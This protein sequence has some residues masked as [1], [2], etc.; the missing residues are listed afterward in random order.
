MNSMDTKNDLLTRDY[1]I[2]NIEEDP[3][4]KNSTKEFFVVLALCM[5]AAVVYGFTLFGIDWG[6]V[7]EY[8]YLFGF[9]KWV[10]VTAIAGICFVIFSLIV[11]MKVVKNENLDDIIEE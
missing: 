10:T 4:L 8:E 2:N 6:P 7:A 1:N 11:F 9:P 5:L 3:R